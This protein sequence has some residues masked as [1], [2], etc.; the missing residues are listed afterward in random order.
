MVGYLL[1]P[2]CGVCK[3]CGLTLAPSS[4]ADRKLSSLTGGARFSRPFHSEI[5][6]WS[7]ADTLGKT[8]PGHRSS[9]RVKGAAEGSGIRYQGPRITILE[10]DDA[11]LKRFPTRHTIWLCMA[12]SV[13][14]EVDVIAFI[15][16]LALQLYPKIILPKFLAVSISDVAMLAQVPFGNASVSAFILGSAALT[17]TIG[18][19]H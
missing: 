16:Y 7:W 15:T 12:C 9:P 11:I 2:R 1:A 3:A 10:I 18:P 4:L 14:S 13:R 19:Q 17:L 6:A 5:R 8:R